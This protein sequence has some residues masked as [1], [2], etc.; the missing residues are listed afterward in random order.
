M[1]NTC[2]NLNSWNAAYLIGR[3]GAAAS[4]KINKHV[5]NATM[6]KVHLAFG[7]Q[8]II[9]ADYFPNQNLMDRSTIHKVIAALD[10]DTFS[11]CQSPHFWLGFLSLDQGDDAQKA[12]ETLK[13]ITK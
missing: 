10:K 11:Q 3:V 5:V 7:V 2:P 12:L 1:K 8:N 6:A 4:G 13:Q 9:Q